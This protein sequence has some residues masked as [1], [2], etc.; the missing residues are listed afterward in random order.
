M[1]FEEKEQTLKNAIEKMTKKLEKNQQA[2]KETNPNNKD[3]LK[4]YDKRVRSN[5]RSLSILK[6]ALSNLPTEKALSEN[7][8]LAVKTALGIN[9]H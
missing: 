3:R 5:K 2:L 6:K 1:T 7:N 9:A 8:N 4:K